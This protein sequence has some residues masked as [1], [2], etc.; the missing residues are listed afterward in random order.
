[1]NWIDAVALASIHAQVIRETGGVPGLLNPGALESAL[2]RPF[3]A[4]SGEALFPEVLDKV[5]A[6]IHSIVAFHPFI[7]GYKRTALVAADVCI[8]LNGLRLAPSKDVEAFFWSIARG[9]RDIEAIAAWLNTHTEPWS[10]PG[11]APEPN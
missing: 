6:L 1:M 9:E 8:R 7:D 2:A 4:F 10:Q 11:A 5:A 3:S